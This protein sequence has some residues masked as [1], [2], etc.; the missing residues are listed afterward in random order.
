M[1]NLSI[2]FTQKD[3]K[4]MGILSRVVLAIIIFSELIIYFI[5]FIALL[6]MIL[7][8]PTISKGSNI[9]IVEEQGKRVFYSENKEL[10]TITYND[11]LVNIYF[12]HNDLLKQST[13]IVDADGI[14]IVQINRPLVGEHSKLFV[15]AYMETIYLALLGYLVSLIFC[16]RN[17]KLLFFSFIKEQ[18]SPFTSEN[19]VRLKN[20]S[21]L[22]VLSML[23]RLTIL[24][25][26]L[27]GFIVKVSLLDCL[28]ILV[29]IILMYIFK[30]GQSIEQ[31]Q[32]Q[33]REDE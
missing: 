29:V 10:L 7:I 23:L 24:P 16:I 33:N 19:V 9:N 1:K 20:I 4:N 32:R 30:Y 22:V 5:A 11:S 31:L 6:Q 13:E 14:T 21:K 28:I 3:R 26:I 2:N 15:I 27:F 12:L 17:T 8:I 18:Q 25:T